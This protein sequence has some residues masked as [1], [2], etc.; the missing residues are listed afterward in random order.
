MGSKFT[1]MSAHATSHLC[2]SLLFTW[3]SGCT[4]FCSC[5]AS[6]WLL[7]SYLCICGYKSTKLPWR[8][9]LLLPR[10]KTVECHITTDATFS[11]YVTPYKSC[12]SRIGC[13]VLVVPPLRQNQ[14]EY[15]MTTPL[16]RN[17]TLLQLCD[18]F[19]SLFL[20]LVC[21]IHVSPHSMYQ[22]YYVFHGYVLYSVGAVW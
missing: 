6:K 4:I 15:I 1:Q 17:I 11:K 5:H 16:G 13:I 21:C 22:Q 7:G 14:L 8:A 3:H 20:L 2:S 12:K 9:S 18:I 10:N 19:W